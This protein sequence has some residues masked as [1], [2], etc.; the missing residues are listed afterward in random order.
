MEKVVPDPF[1]QHQKWVYLWIQKL[2]IYSLF[3]LYVQAE[4]I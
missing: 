1:L 2:N 4:N 3:L